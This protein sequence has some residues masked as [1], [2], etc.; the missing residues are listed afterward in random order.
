[1]KKRIDII[2]VKMLKESSIMYEKR[3]ITSSNEAARLIKDFIGDADREIFV[4]LC[5][6]TKN[7]PTAIHTVSIGTLNS[8]MVH[9]REVFKAA[10]LANSANILLAHNH[11]S[12]NVA[13]SKEDIEITKRLNEAGKILGI[14]VLDHIIVGEY[15]NFCSLKEKGFN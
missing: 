5:L 1:M 13:P 3:K 9:P 6:N 15:G 4:I 11:P 7:E 2:S 14:E 12:G 10:I 8:S